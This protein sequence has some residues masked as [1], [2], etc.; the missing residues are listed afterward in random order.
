MST[1]DTVLLILALACFVAAGFGATFGGKVKGIGWFG[2]ALWVL[3][4]LVG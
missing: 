3:S 2:L 1:I 4:V